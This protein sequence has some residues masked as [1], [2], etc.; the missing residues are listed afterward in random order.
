MNEKPESRKF[1]SGI[2]LVQFGE[3]IYTPT[4]PVGIVEHPVAKNAHQTGPNSEVSLEC[5][6][7]SRVPLRTWPG[8]SF[9][10]LRSSSQFG[11]DDCRVTL[12]VF[13]EADQPHGNYWMLLARGELAHSPWAF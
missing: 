6:D 2:L 11:P 4:R 13:A 9:Y 7:G 5:S 10:T 12:R 8:E 1:F 3:H